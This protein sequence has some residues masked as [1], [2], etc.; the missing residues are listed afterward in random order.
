KCNDRASPWRSRLHD[1]EKPLS[2]V[3]LRAF[4]GTHS[5]MPCIQL[6][7]DLI[8]SFIFLVT[9]WLYLDGCIIY[10]STTALNNGEK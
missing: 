4:A 3:S 5:K 6:Q 1:R 7:V 2:K 8:P 10:S 9:Y